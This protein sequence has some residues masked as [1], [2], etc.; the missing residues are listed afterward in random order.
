MRNLFFAAILTG[1]A[2]LAEAPS[3]AAD[4][5]QCGLK[6]FASIDLM[7]V[8]ENQLLVP[9]VIQDTPAY[10]TL[11]LSNAFSGIG[12]NSAHDLSLAIRLPLPMS[13]FGLAETPSRRRLQPVHSQSVMCVSRTRVS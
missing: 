12:E 6:Q 8:G 10:M 7:A 3:V 4:N 1:I 13:E 5:N 9:V 11:A 2:V